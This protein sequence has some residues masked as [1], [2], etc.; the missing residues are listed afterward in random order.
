MFSRDQFHLSQR[1][2][3]QIYTPQYR[4]YKHGEISLW[5]KKPDAF[6]TISWQSKTLR[7]NI[8][9]GKI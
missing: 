3:K 5:G 2:I 7:F 9:A 4:F 1:G 6:K 8:K